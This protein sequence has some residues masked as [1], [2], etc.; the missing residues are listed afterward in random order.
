MEACIL[1][2]SNKIRSRNYN[3][4]LEQITDNMFCE[5]SLTFDDANVKN[6]L[7]LACD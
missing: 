7:T 1:F 2:H 4:F 5:W 3:K 6:D